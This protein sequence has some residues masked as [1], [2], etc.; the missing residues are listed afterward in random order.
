[1]FATTEASA[2]EDPRL[3]ERFWREAVFRFCG[4]E[5][6]ECLILRNMHGLEQGERTAWL[7][8]AAESVRLWFPSVAPGGPADPGATG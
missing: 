4:I 3:I 7:R 1:M 8:G 2:E 6:S 5:R